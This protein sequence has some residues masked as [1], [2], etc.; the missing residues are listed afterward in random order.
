MPLSARK[1]RL[2]AP[3]K[4]NLC[5]SVLKRRQDGYHELETWM[6]K[7]DLCDLLTVELVDRSGI[8]LTC[9]DPGLPA[10][11]DNLVFRAAEFFLNEVAG[12]VSAGVKIF[13]EKKIPVA[14]GLGGGSSDAGAVLKGLN[15]LYGEP[16]S[17]DKLLQLGRR[18]GADVPF[19]VANHDAVIARG[20]GD[21]MYPVD[22]LVDYIFVLVNPGFSVSTRWVFDNLFLTTADKK[23]KLSCFQKRKTGFLPLD[24]MHNDLEKVTC[25]RYSEIDRMKRMLLDS[26]ASKAL[27]S[28][29]GATV[30]GVF[31]RKEKP[32][33][34]DFERVAGRLIRKF[35]DKVF[36]TKAR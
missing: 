24:L 23:Y 29:S 12:S 20:I 3:A 11:R 7:L 35:G 5:L 1:I 26:G 13:L 15:R 16:L 32:D 25:A 10:G 14:A 4:I 19:F 6:Q 8:S 33:E 30:F 36:I 27:M 28:G 18:L 9:S 17:E 2:R 31:P 34:W 21:I 22:S